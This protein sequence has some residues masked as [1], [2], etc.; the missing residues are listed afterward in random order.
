MMM[1]IVAATLGVLS[2]LELLTSL[3][4]LLR[5]MN[6]ANKKTFIQCAQTYVCVESTLDLKRAC[7]PS[8]IFR[9]SI[10]SLP[11]SARLQGLIYRT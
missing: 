10:L 4:M 2:A 7:I 11:V 3:V 1:M 8:V 5:Y 9:S 6:S